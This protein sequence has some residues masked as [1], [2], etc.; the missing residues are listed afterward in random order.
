[1]VTIL[2]TIV[3]FLYLALGGNQTRARL[4]STQMFESQV[5][6]GKALDLF[7]G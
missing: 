6:T 1:M 5:Y 4:N 2:E 3:L 7:L